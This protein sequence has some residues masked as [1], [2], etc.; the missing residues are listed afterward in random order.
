VSYEAPTRCTVCPVWGAGLVTWHHVRHRGGGGSDHPDN[1]MPLCARHHTE[2][3]KIGLSAFSD[4]Y[5]RAASWLNEHRWE[6]DPWDRW[7]GPIEVRR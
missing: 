7:R 3:H 6:L 5:A 4:K 2:I 1:L